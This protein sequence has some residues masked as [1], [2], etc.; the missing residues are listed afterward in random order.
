M[1]KFDLERAKAG[2]PVRTTCGKNARII[3]FDRSIPT[4]QNIIMLV[5]LGGDNNTSVY[6][7]PFKTSN[8]GVGYPYSLEMKPK[9]VTK[10]V[11]YNTAKRGKLCHVYESEVRARASAVD[12]DIV[13]SFTYE[14]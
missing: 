3:C 14:V 10:W 13:T 7:D 5:E 8:D 4:G 11:R 2:D 12:G 6:E 9:T 1:S